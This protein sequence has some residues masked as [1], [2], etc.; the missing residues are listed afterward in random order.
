MRDIFSVPFF[1]Q[2]E[3]FDASESDEYKSWELFL[4]EINCENSVSGPFKILSNVLKVSIS[5]I[6]IPKLE[7]A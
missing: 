5:K 2:S 3:Y 7:K 4:R 1:K 6:K